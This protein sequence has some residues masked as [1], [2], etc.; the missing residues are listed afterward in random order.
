MY[1]EAEQSYE[2]V[3]EFENTD[4]PE[5]EEELNKVRSLQ[6]QEMGFS[7][8]QSEAAIRNNLTVQAA[9]ESIFVYTKEDNKCAESSSDID[10]ND[11][12][13]NENDSENEHSKKEKTNFNSS[14]S[15]SSSTTSYHANENNSNLEGSGANPQNQTPSTSLWIGNVD[16]DVTEEI[17][18]EMFSQYGQLANVRCLPEKYC[19]F[20]NFKIKEDAHKAMQNLQ[21]G[22]KRLYYIHII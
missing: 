9:L 16:P 6:L 19:A 17:L 1:K 8:S 21:V 10:E 20:V 18:T 15:S 4:D 2:K 12:D 11:Y 22:S 5:L 13:Y 7:K 3:L 14:S